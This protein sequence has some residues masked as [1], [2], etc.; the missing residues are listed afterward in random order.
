MSSKLFKLG[1]LLVLF[2]ITFGSEGFSSNKDEAFYG[3]WKV[4]EEPIS[5]KNVFSIEEA[6]IRIGG[7]ILKY[8][9]DGATYFEYKGLGQPYEIKVVKKPI[10]KNHIVTNEAFIKYQFKP[11]RKSLEDLGIQSLKYLLITFQVDGERKNS[12]G[13]VEEKDRLLVHVEDVYFWA[14]RIKE[15]K[16]ID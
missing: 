5:E 8:S 13:Y 2:L 11:A 12:F 9:K 1:S 7:K 15:E 3:R 6:K 14:R 4:D 16:S 10:Y